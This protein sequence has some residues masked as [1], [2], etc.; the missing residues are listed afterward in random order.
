MQ[1]LEVAQ[2]SCELIGFAVVMGLEDV[3]DQNVDLI[4]RRDDLALRGELGHPGTSKIT[5]TARVAG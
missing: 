3:R 2:R 5:E 1:V 4:L